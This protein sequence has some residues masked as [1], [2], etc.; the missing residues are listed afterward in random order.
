MV[1]AA[2]VFFARRLAL[3]SSTW[4]R[5]W[6]FN[7]LSRCRCSVWVMAIIMHTWSKFIWHELCLGGAVRHIVGTVFEVPLDRATTA[8]RPS[9]YQHSG[10]PAISAYRPIWQAS[11]LRN[12]SVTDAQSKKKPKCYTT[13]NRST[14][15]LAVQY[16][17][18]QKVTQSATIR[19]Q[20]KQFNYNSVIMWNSWAW[21]D[22]LC[23]KAIQ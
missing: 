5:P 21:I 22:N 6:A 11:I 20:P 15:Q 10:R 14:T 16:F 3:L 18:L 7:R 4:A 12:Q 17:S 13:G 9:W 2:P 8:F 19:L 23:I 1:T